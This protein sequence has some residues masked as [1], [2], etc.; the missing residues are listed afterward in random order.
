MKSG[1][2]ISQEPLCVTA[3]SCITTS[4]SPS[5]TAGFVNGQNRCFDGSSDLDHGTV[6]TSSFDGGLVP[7][8]FAA[9]RRT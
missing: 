8:P 6:T 2:T 1:Y 9:R 3:K 7:H 4:C 5:P